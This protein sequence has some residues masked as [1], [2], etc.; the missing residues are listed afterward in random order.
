MMTQQEFLDVLKPRGT[1]F[2]PPS[3]IGNINIINVNLQKIRAAILPNFIIE[4]YKVC[5]G[6]KLGNGYIFGPLPSGKPGKHPIPDIF[7]IN[8]EL[9]NFAALRGK[10]IFGRND[11]FWFAFDSFGNCTMLDNLGL[12][13][14]RKYDDP[15]RAMLDCLIGGKI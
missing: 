14:L 7:N 11:L 8:N 2:A 9:T 13:V 5:G 1:A 4:L 15:Y 6:I 10:T 3:P 12:N